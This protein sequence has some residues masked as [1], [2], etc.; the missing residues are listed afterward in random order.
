MDILTSKVM[1]STETQAKD[2]D[3]NIAQQIDRVHI[4]L[5]TNIL[6][7]ITTIFTL[8]Y[9]FILIPAISLF[10]KIVSKKKKISHID[11]H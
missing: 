10:K 8:L 4:K 6:N 9:K 2:K 3:K 5:L 7:L 1:Q 11:F